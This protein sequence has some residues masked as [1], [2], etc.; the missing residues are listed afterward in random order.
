MKYSI[1]VTIS[2]LAVST[3]FSGCDS[4]PGYA[5]DGSGDCSAALV[6][7]YDQIVS[8]IQGVQGLIT[9]QDTTGSTVEQQEI[10]EEQSQLAT[11]SQEI[12]NFQSNYPGVSCSAM[13]NGSEVTVDQSQ[14]SALA[15]DVSEA[16]QSLATDGSL[17]PVAG[18]ADCSN[19]GMFT[20]NLTISKDIT[21]AQNSVQ[22]AEAN[23]DPTQKSQG[24]E[25][26]QTQL[27]TASALLATYNSEYAG[28]YCDL[29]GAGV[30]T[31][32][33]LSGPEG[34]QISQLEQRIATDLAAL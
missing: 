1:L 17:L 2:V 29:N 24:L 31:S 16:Q 33:A 12:S 7:D 4:G 28:A 18:V 27:Q 34:T 26:A 30:L 23:V 14:M 9:T 15:D 10:Q 3:V 11:A 32:S 19:S 6:G 22:A 13:S 21:L 25:A 5:D 8:D 20:D